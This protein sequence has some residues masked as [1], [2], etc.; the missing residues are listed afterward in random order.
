MKNSMIRFVLKTKTTFTVRKLTGGCN[1]EQNF[2]AQVL[3][4]PKSESLPQYSNTQ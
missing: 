1:R 3:Y 4:K 2:I